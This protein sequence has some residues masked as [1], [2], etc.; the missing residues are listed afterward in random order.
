MTSIKVRRLASNP[1]KRRRSTA[2]P[3]RRVKARK[4]NPKRHARRTLSAKQIKFFGSPAQKAALKRKRKR[5]VTAAPVRRRKRVA[6][7]NPVRRRRR[8]VAKAAPRRRRRVLKANPAPRKRRR[9]A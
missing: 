9:V 8:V 5:K 4:S 6:K 3:V 1:H 2:R 7:A